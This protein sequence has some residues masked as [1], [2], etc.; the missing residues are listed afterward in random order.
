MDCIRKEWWT[1]LEVADAPRNSIRNVRAVK[2]DTV[3]MTARAAGSRLLYEMAVKPW[4]R[5]CAVLAAMRLIK[6]TDPPD[7]VV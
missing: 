3:A 7:P 1:G 2:T 6:Q 4:D 5:Q